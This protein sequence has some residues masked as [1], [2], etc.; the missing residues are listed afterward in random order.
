ME[1]PPYLKKK[2]RLS[3]LRELKIHLHGAGLH[4]VCESARCPNI[5]ECYGERTATFMIL[6]D[7]CTRNCRFCSVK[8]GRPSVLK[9]NEPEAIAN[10]AK[11]M[12][13]KYIVVTSVTRDD[14]S[15][16]GALAFKRTVVAIKSALPYAKVEVLTPDFKNI[17]HSW[18]LIAESGIDVFAHNIETVPSIYKI[19][20][21]GADYERSLKLLN[22]I[23]KKRNNV[24]IK[25][26]LM[27][28]LGEKQDEVKKVLVDLKNT[29]CQIVTIGQYLRPTKYSLPVQRY[30][31]EDEY[32]EYMR[33]GK[34]IGLNY[35]FAGAFIRSSYRAEFVFNEFRKLFSSSIFHKN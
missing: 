28:G 10:T 8:K 20:R 19:V 1:L 14:L 13:L 26:G 15:D 35:V 3:E 5:T 2:I 27:V 34:E 17:E 25:S 31:D 24:I 18:A 29:G 9:E 22:F 12:G 7:T 23:H 11:Q 32:R 21:P 4:T 6:G 33:F 30:V 16:G